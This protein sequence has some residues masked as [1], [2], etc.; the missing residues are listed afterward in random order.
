M[1]NYRHPDWRA[2]K[3]LTRNQPGWKKDLLSRVA[4]LLGEWSSWADKVG[5]RTNEV[6][7]QYKNPVDS[8]FSYSP[9]GLLWV[10]FNTWDSQRKNPATRAVRFG[11]DTAILMVL[12]KIPNGKS[13][14]WYLLAR[15][16]YQFA[17]KDL[18]IEFSR[19]WIKKG[20]KIEDYGWKL[21]ERDF[22]RLKESPD[23][24]S[25]YEERMGNLV[26][27]NNAELGN[28]ISK[29]LIVLEMRPGTDIDQIRKNLA[30]AKLHQ[31]YGD[32]CPDFLDEDDLVSQPVV[33]AMDEAVNLMNAHVA[34]ENGA[35]L[36]LFGEDFS[37][38]C[39][40]RFLNLHGW[41]FPQY[42]LHGEEI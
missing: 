32:D 24:T 18:F 19:G 14:E 17:G 36:A 15:K 1:S 11:P 37:Q 21:F 20:T 16:K 22:P 30:D 41:Q 23:V 8:Y 13:F 3:E 25:V 39:W 2:E 6:Q 27:E 31:E 34:N 38:R 35:R 10:R 42:R 33:L 40:D 9:L 28:K 7:I 29:H 12:V 5:F 4:A 26:W